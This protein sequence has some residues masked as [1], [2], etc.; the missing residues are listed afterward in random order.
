[1]AQEAIFLVRVKCQPYSVVC[2]KDTVGFRRRAPSW[3]VRGK[4]TPPLKLKHLVFGCSVESTNLLAF[5]IFGNAKQKS[6]I[7]YTAHVVL[8]NLTFN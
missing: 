6:Q 3:E 7:A 5:L 1:M 4:A 8:L 2:I